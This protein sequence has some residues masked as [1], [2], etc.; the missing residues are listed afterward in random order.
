LADWHATDPDAATRNKVNEWLMDLVEDPLRRGR[1][2]PEHPGIWFGRM[3]G[4][5]LGV[6]F[7]P[8]V[9]RRSICVVAIA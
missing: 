1:E 4:T 7:V 8:D 6:T 5:N 9:D 3:R 2:D